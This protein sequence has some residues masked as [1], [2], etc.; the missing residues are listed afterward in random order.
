M[1]VLVVSNSEDETVDYLCMR[2]KDSGVQFT[3]INT[4]MAASMCSVFVSPKRV[5]L[6]VYESSLSA[7]DVQ[8]VWY[9]RPKP[10]TKSSS[11]NGYDEA[12]ATAEWT[13]ALEGFLAYIPATRWINHPSR[14][15]NASSKLEQLT[16]AGQHGLTVPPWLCT[17][18]REEALSFFE[19]QDGRIVAKPLYCGY[20]ERETPNSDTVI[21]T[22]RVSR[23]HLGSSS[24]Q[25]G[26]PTL[27]QR[28][29]TGG[30]DVRVTIVD[31]DVI[32][33]RLS[34]DGG[35][36]DIRRN[37]M[38]GVRYSGQGVPNQVKEAL[39][40]LVRSYG[41]RFAAIDMMLYQDEWL[42]LEINPNGQW[43]WLDL[44]GRAEIY[45]SF[46][47]AFGGAR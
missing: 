39:H 10:L 21:Y 37:N 41:L 15:M 18:S 31:D 46:L 1:S 29:V 17:T 24:S 45:R 7:T 2:M 36:V 8:V 33:V 9:R 22:S 40:S 32:A 34:K 26:A 43:A 35:E 23:E 4:E 30:V 13:A 12:F 19:E 11:G 42:F 3:R 6:D 27:F 38:V 14:I 5:V 25:L 47:K 44:I 20:I 16:R 28:E